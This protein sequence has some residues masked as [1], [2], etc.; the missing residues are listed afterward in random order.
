MSIEKLPVFKDFP[1]EKGL[2]KIV[3]WIKNEIYAPMS[4]RVNFLLSLINSG[5]VEIPADDVAPGTDGNWRWRHDGTDLVLQNKVGGDWVDT[6]IKMFTTNEVRVGDVDGDDYTKITA[7]GDIILF[8]TDRTIESEKFKVTAIGG[9]AV[10]LTNKTG[11]DSVKGELVEASTTDDFAVR[12]NDANGDH[13]F[14]VFLDS[15]IADGEEAWVV[16]SGMADVMLQDGTLSTHGNWARTSLTTAGR[17]NL[18]FATPPGGGVT[19]IDR[20]MKEIGHCF[21]TVSAG[22]DKL[23]RCTLHFN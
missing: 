23:A 8:G 19:E 10:K 6:A 12:L 22:T 3:K 4:R 17:A 15:G 7:T 11:L 13:C 2:S 1:P 21:Q 5:F 18:T 9:N 14:A 20:H 16:Y